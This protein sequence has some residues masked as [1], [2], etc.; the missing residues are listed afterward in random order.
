L[1]DSIRKQ[2]FFD[3][4]I[5]ARAAITGKMEVCEDLLRAVGKIRRVT[6]AS[7]VP[8]RRKAEGYVSRG[9]LSE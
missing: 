1:S 3:D 8:H 6:Y 7:L 2:Q 9:N 5:G 4:S